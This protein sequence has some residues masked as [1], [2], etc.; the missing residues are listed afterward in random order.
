M[1]AGPPVAESPKQTM[2]IDGTTEEKCNAVSRVTR[3]E[4]E[5]IR[6]KM[7]EDVATI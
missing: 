6:R 4:V 2:R 5:K 3:I 7:F 1:S